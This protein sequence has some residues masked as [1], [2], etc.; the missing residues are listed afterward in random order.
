LQKLSGESQIAF[1]EID[2]TGY[3]DM[4]SYTYADLYEIPRYNFPR[5]YEYWDY[6]K[7]D[8]Y[9]PSGKM[10]KAEDIDYIFENAEPETTILSVRAFS[11]RY[12]Q[13]PEKT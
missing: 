7:Q 9:D 6:A 13:T 1:W 5:L 10:T 8:Y 2:Q 11:Q 3:D 4:D 12:M